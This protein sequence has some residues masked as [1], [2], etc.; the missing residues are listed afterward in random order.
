MKFLKIITQPRIS[1]LDLPFIG[2]VS[3]MLQ[4]QQ[5]IHVCYLIL[6]YI[7]IQITIVMLIAYNDN[8]I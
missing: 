2:A 6:V 5:Y 3:S 7:M 4:D 8:D 1:W